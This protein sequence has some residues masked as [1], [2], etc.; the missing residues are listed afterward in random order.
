MRPVAE[1]GEADVE[2][3]YGC[4]HFLVIGLLDCDDS[5]KLA[6]RFEIMKDR[7]HVRLDCR[8]VVKYSDLIQIAN[9]LDVMQTSE[10]S[11]AGHVANDAKVD[12]Y[13]AEAAVHVFHDENAFAGRRQVLAIF[14]V[15][16]FSWQIDFEM[17]LVKADFDDAEIVVSRNAAMSRHRFCQ[18]QTANKRPIP[19]L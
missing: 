10:T 16:S 9:L 3:K 15:L 18:Q 11:L 4:V 2:R 12:W 17:G 7:E 19:D 13:F 14:P 8:R 1:T 5:D 6:S